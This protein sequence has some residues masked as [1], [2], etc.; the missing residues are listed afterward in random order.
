[1]APDPWT[2]V[3][4]VCTDQAFGELG[5]RQVRAAHCLTPHASVTRIGP[6]VQRRGER[7]GTAPAAARQGIAAHVLRQLPTGNPLNSAEPGDRIAHQCLDIRNPVRGRRII[8]R[9]PLQ[10]EQAAELDLHQDT[11]RS[12]GWIVLDV[13]GRQ[14]GLFQRTEQLLAVCMDGTFPA[15]KF[16]ATAPDDGFCMDTPEDI[17]DECCAERADQNLHGNCSVSPVCP[18]DQVGIIH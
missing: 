2:C 9:D 16:R 11:V 15:G 18:F 6:G 3:E 14:R 12:S 10:A 4:R 7:S 5:T 8:Q 1:M 13:K 17:P